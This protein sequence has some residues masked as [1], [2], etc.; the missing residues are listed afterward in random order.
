MAD[1]LKAEVTALTRPDKKNALNGAT[2]DRPERAE[3]K[4]AVRVRR[5]EGATA[6]R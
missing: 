2:S 5:V 6:D 4:P 3:G 1:C